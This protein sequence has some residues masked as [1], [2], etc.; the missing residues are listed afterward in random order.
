MLVVSVVIIVLILAIASV[1]SYFTFF[2]K[3][4]DVDEGFDEVSVNYAGPGDVIDFYNTTSGESTKNATAT[5]YIDDESNYLILSVDVITTDGPG[6]SYYSTEVGIHIESKLDDDLKPKELK[7][8]VRNKEGE[9]I[10]E[11]IYNFQSVFLETEHADGWP[12]EYNDLGSRGDDWAYFGFDLKDEDFTIDIRGG[13]DIPHENYPN[14]YTLEIKAVMKG[15]S[16]DVE[17]VV[18]VNIE[19]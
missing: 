12:Y 2:Q 18:D 7:L 15:L 16:E 1:Y 5:T 8:M 14:P 17:A 13:W 4:I 11:N 10:D 19:E 6:G 3:D 9:D